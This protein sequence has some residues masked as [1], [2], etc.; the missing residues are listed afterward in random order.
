MRA[1]LLDSLARTVDSEKLSIE[2][3]ERCQGK[4]RLSRDSKKKSDEDHDLAGLD[5]K[6]KKEF[7]TVILKQKGVS[8]RN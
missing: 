3:P 8:R 1:W 2:P 4:S 7:N 5:D 6:T